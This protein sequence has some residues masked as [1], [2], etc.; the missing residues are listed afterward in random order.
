MVTREPKIELT[1]A[2]QRAAQA[3]DPYPEAAV[4]IDRLRRLEA[5]LLEQR[6]EVRA[7]LREDLGKPEVES[8]LTEIYTVVSEAR[9]ARRHVAGWM[10]P[11]R[12]RTPLALF[13]T[14][15][16]VRC[17]PKGVALILAPWNFPVNLM[18]G[19]LA[20]ALAAGNRAILKPSE[21]APASAGWM[22][23]M[24]AQRFDSTEVALFEGQGELAAQLTQMPFDHIFFTG[25]PRVGKL[26]MQAAAQNLTPVTLELGGKSPAVVDASADL[27]LTAERLVWGKFT[28][29]GQTCI[30]PDYV[31]VPQAGAAQLVAELERELERAFGRE[32]ARAQSPDYGRIIHEQHFDGLLASLEQALAQG[33]RVV[34]GGAQYAD[35]AARYLPPTVL[36]D[37]PAGTR[38]LDEEIFGPILPIVTYAELPEALAFIRARPKPLA[39][40]AFS[41]DAARTEQILRST[42]AGSTCV[43]DTLFQYSHH[44]LPFGGVGTSGHGKSH[45]E[46]GFRSFSNERS[47]L[48]P[49]LHARPARRLRPPATPGVRRLV[50]WTLRYL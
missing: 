19:P 7:A 38:L 22:A 8:D 17:E 41:E 43:N 30:A 50:D 33:A 6:G 36:V 31:L 21:L 12:V 32:E 42:T 9:H 39:L 37:V 4:R 15:G 48:E 29:A 16:H 24:L 26:V 18:L 13:G 44:G 3:A 40:Y 14:R 23:D 46:Y 11:R 34:T 25:S 10:R 20:S 1:F 45:G 49:W 28:N 35:R 5:A 27:A 47:V 2:A